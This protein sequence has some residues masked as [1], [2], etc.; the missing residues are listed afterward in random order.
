MP[1]TATWRVMEMWTTWTV[2]FQMDS[3]VCPPTL[4]PMWIPTFLLK[5]GFHGSKKKLSGGCGME[6][7]IDRGSLIFPSFAEEGQHKFPRQCCFIDGTLFSD[8]ISPVSAEVLSQ[9]TVWNQ[10]ER[11]FC[12]DSCWAPKLHRLCWNCHILRCTDLL[13]DLT[14]HGLSSSLVYRRWNTGTTPLYGTRRFWSTWPSTTQTALFTR[15]GTLL[16]TEDMGSH[17]STA[18]PTETFSH[19]GK[20]LEE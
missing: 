13:L 5:A 15:S 19:K 6:F 7:S 20:D 2:V 9:S 14:V 16:Q 12:A 4:L 17:C 18:A 3:H 11:A 10:S 1:S 8:H